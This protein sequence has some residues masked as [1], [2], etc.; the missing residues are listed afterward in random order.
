MRD[1]RMVLKVTVA[2]CG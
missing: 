2:R 1:T